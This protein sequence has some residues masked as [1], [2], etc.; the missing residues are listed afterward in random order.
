MKKKWSLVYGFIL[1]IL[2]SVSSIS[3]ALAAAPVHDPKPIVMKINDSYEPTGDLAYVSA[4]QILVPLSLLKHY[5][6]ANAAYL[7]DENVITFA[8]KPERFTIGGAAQKQIKDPVP[9]SFPAICLKNQYYLDIAN[10]DSLL[11][12]NISF[13]YSGNLILQLN[14][15]AVG[16]LVLQSAT[17]KGMPK[18]KINL[19]W[20]VKTSTQKLS[21]E[22][23]P[24]GLNVLAPTWFAVTQSNGLIVNKADKDYVDLAHSKGYKVWALITN[25]F[26]PD[27]THELLQNEV[28]QDQVLNQ[29]LFYAS[30]YELDGINLDFENI[31]ESDKMAFTHFVEKISPPLGRQ[32]LVVSLDVTV[33]A[34]VPNWSKCYDRV[35]L[36]KAVDYVMVMTYDEHWAKS[37]VS[38]SVASYGWVKEGIENTLLSIPK[39]KLLLG[40]PFYTRE[41]IERSDETGRFIVR[42]RTLSME[43]EE[44]IIQ[45]YHLTP[46]WLEKEGQ[47]YTEYQQDGNRHRIWLEEDR[48]IGLKADL[49]DQYQLAGVASWRKGFEKN[50]IWN[51]LN[52]KLHSK[53]A[54]DKN[55]VAES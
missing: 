26:D 31:Y 51:V 17:V 45:D 49:V 28:A 38:G 48:S 25:S 8:V 35:N 33:P 15:P 34:N 53:Q 22:L 14:S 32:N 24:K 46:Q 18:E 36:S 19:V 42:S 1:L 12:V 44:K 20:D 55:S 21:N 50:S 4:T 13:D 41:W 6:T 43:N 52:N 16:P 29:L 27:L 9:V 2:A 3:V 23:P 11:G 47:Y 7:S 37:P 30:Y 5:F 39:E 54:N 40:L 10:L